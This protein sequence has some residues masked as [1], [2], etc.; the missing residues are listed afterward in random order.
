MKNPFWILLLLGSTILSCGQKKAA[1]TTT[2]NTPQQTDFIW[3]P[4]SKNDSVK[5][6]G[7]STRYF[8]K[9]KDSVIF[10]HYETELYKKQED[11][12]NP[13][14]KKQSI[15][16][17]KALSEKTSLPDTIY[18]QAKGTQNGTFIKK[19]S[20]FNILAGFDGEE[21]KIS[22]GEKWKSRADY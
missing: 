22:D 4:I 11:A 8:N 12:E 6:R 3:L 5:F 1:K 16:V 14:F 13:L 19:S 15:L 18:I 21:W 20:D 9:G 10:A 7:F 2:E 17:L